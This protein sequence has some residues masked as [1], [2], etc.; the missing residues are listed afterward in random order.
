MAIKSTI[1]SIYGDQ[2]E[3]VLNDVV[4]GQYN[5]VMVGYGFSS[6]TSFWYWENESWNNGVPN[7][8]VEPVRN[9]T[10]WY[11]GTNFYL[12]YYKEVE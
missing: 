3:I 8:V 5:Y 6:Y 2:T 4:T 11:N 12:T 7:N 9:Q 1:N 10:V